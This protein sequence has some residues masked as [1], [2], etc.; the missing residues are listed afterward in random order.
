[1]NGFYGSLEKIRIFEKGTPRVSMVFCNY[2][3]HHDSGKHTLKF[4]KGSR[5]LR[6]FGKLREKSVKVG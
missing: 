6:D 3:S 1:M 4:T 2:T 5:G